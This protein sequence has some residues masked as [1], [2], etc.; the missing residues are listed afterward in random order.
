[1]GLYLLGIMSGLALGLVAVCAY[2][3]LCNRQAHLQPKCLYCWFCAR[4]SAAFDD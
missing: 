2:F 4:V 1:M 3:W